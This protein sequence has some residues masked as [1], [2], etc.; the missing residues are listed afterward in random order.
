MMGLS[1]LKV[2]LITTFRWENFRWLEADFAAPPNIPNIG[3]RTTWVNMVL[4]G[5]GVSYK[6]TAYG[7]PVDSSISSQ[8][9]NGLIHT[10]SKN[11]Y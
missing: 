6:S 11:H 4:H 1:H 3:P 2:R 8:E 7:V 9:G 5:T 10:S